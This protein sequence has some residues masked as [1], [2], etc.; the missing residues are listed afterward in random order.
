METLTDA[1]TLIADLLQAL[2]DEHQSNCS[3]SP[4]PVGQLEVETA[5]FLTYAAEEQYRHGISR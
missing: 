2:R 4:C 1:V 3:E 5:D